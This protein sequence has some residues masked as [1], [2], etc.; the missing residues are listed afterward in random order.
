MAISPRPLTF[1][2]KEELWQHAFSRLVVTSWKA[3]FPV[4]RGQTDIRAV[5]N[6]L[7]LLHAGLP[8]VLFAEGTRRP[9]GL[10]RPHP[11][12]GYL[13][14][15]A[16]SPCFLWRSAVPSRWEHLERD[17][18]SDLHRPIRPD[19][20]RRSGRPLGKR[21]CPR[22]HAPH[23]GAPPAG[24]ARRVCGIPRSRSMSALAERRRAP[25]RPVGIV[26]AVEPEGLAAQAGVWLRATASSP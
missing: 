15:R 1:M 11:G 7:E 8:V 16:H 13:A 21:D 20:H 23:R 14:S 26:H 2:A 25:A 19:L 5:R 3:A 12:I 17:P 6:A 9:T 24:A 4:R 10:G 22:D 18:L